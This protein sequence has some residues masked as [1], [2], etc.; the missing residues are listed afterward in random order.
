MKQE[1]SFYKTKMRITN[2]RKCITCGATKTSNWYNHAKPV[3]YI[4]A[5]CYMKEL[6]INKKTNKN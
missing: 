6:R 4:C 1:G 5:A 3:Q 2:D